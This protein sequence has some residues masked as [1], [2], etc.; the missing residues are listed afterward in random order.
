MFS[1]RHKSSI[2]YNL[3]VSGGDTDSLYVKSGR[4]CVL[5]LV[6]TW[7]KEAWD[8]PGKGVARVLS[9][10]F[11]SNDWSEDYLYLQLTLRGPLLR[12]GGCRFCPS[13]S[14]LFRLWLA[15]LGVQLTRGSELRPSC[16]R[17]FMCELIRKLYTSLRWYR[18]VSSLSYRLYNRWGHSN[19]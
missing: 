14:C 17:L 7:V 12:F 16:Q 6:A 19:G 18:N 2:R 9:G 5:L 3:L 8:N 1:I 15:V 13:L 10:V 11:R 4:S